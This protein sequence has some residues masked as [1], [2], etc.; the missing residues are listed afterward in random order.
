MTHTMADRLR[1][2]KRTLEQSHENHTACVLSTRN[3][4]TV[5]ELVKKHEAQERSDE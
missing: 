3:R 4:R 2:L 5:E 1:E